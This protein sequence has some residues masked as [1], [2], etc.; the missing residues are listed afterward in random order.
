MRT[1]FTVAAVALALLLAPGNPGEQARPVSAAALAIQVTSSADTSPTGG[2]LCPHVARCTL[3]EA[4]ETLNAEEGEGPYAIT[5]AANVFPPDAPALIA[6]G[7]MPLPE[8]ARDDVA[9]DASERGVRIIDANVSLTTAHNGLVTSGARITVR[10]LSIE[11]F[12]GTCLLVTGPAS[13]VGGD[14]ALGHGNRFGDC[15]TAIAVRGAGTTVSGNRVGFGPNSEPAPVETGIA[16]AAS[17]VVVGRDFGPVGLA[18]FVGNADIGIL[19]G[20]DVA[21]PFSGV[22]VHRNGIGRD[23]AGSA[24]P[25]G[26]AIDL[27]QPGTSTSVF[28]NHIANAGTGISIRADFAGQSVTGNRIESNVFADLSGL[29]IDLGADG[30]RNGNDAGDEDIGAN[31]LRNHPLVTRAVQSSI[32][33]TA[34][35]CPGCRVELYVAQHTPGGAKDFGTTPLP[36]GAVTTDTSGNFAIANPAVAPGEWVTGL[37][38]DPAGNTSEFG[39][40]SRVGA[41][42]VQCA[43]VTLAPGWTH[44]GYFGAEPVSLGETFSADPEGRVTA[45][46]HAQDGTAGFERWFSTTPMGRTL[47]TV[48][49][50]EA[51]WFFANA[52]VTLP[53]GFSLSA[54]LPVQLK[55]GWNDFVYIGATADLRDALAPL[56]GNYRD[57]YRF[58][59]GGTGGHWAKLGNSDT[60][61]WARDLSVVEACGT[62]Q[63]FLEAPATLVPI[64]P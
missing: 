35:G 57:L 38:T 30:L 26:R 4:I 36:G 46:Y 39:P 24:A 60:P 63:V 1:A 41:G 11:R 40:S 16:V 6:V 51:Y 15:T 50:G 48:Q 43:N 62:Y 27:A 21:P 12:A 44:T 32:I 18:N 42:A 53:G 3:R 22:K 19:V 29:A 31:G 9:I 37:V 56:A 14:A 20:D 33:G 8:L 10:G 64:Q 7:A 28:S 17:N 23:P 55:A 59:E 45:I 58:T 13:T 47:S 49:P 61:A 34:E 52:P 5:F 54:P 2:P 25:V